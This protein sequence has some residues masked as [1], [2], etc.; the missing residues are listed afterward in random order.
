MGGHRAVI[1]LTAVVLTASGCSGGSSDDDYSYRAPADPVSTRT[2]TKPRVPVTRTT[3]AVVVPEALAGVVWGRATDT[4]EV[5]LKILPNGRYRTVEIYSPAESG[6]LYQLQRVEDG[7]AQVSRDRLRL[8]GIKATA[9]R[10]ADDDP[11]G[12]YE[13]ATTTRTGIYAWQVSGNELHLVDGNGDD[14]V[15]TRQES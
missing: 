15:F 2:T 9:K 5:V 14:A 13:R 4:M 3:A 6:G 7:V 11:N 10:T 8:A 12:N 1:L